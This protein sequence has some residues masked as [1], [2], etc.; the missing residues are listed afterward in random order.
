[1]IRHMLLLTLY[2]NPLFIL[3]VHAKAHALAGGMYDVQL[4]ERVPYQNNL[5]IA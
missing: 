1:M 3:Q 5:A 2:P 4:V